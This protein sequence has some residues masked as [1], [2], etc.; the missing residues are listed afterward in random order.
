MWETAHPDAGRTPNFPLIAGTV[1][2]LPTNSIVVARAEAGSNACF[3]RYILGANFGEKKH[4][5]DEHLNFDAA[6]AFLWQIYTLEGTDA[7]VQAAKDMIYAGAAWIAQ[8][9]GP[10]EA[11]RILRIVGAAQEGKDWP[12]RLRTRS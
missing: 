1:A 9:H 12:K 5:A 3:G 2:P 11:R 6:I 10:D 4:M 7:S 8:E